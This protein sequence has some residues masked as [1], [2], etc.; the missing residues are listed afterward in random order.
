MVKTASLTENSDRSSEAKPPYEPTTH[1]HDAIRRLKD[2]AKRRPPAPRYKIQEQDGENRLEADHPD[3]DHNAILL[4]DTFATANSQL[5]QGLLD[6]LSQLTD[7]STE[8][9]AADLNFL[10]GAVRGIGPQDE[11]ET[12]LAVQMAAVHKATL[13][14]A[15]RLQNAETIALYDANS[16][17]LNK[18]ARTFT[19]Q[20]E[21]LKRYRTGGEQTIKVQHVNVH[22][23]GQAIVG[24]VRN[25]R[26]GRGDGKKRR[27]SHEPGAT[28]A[29]ACPDADG[30]ALLGHVEEDRMPLPCSSIEGQESVPVSRRTGRRT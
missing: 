2:R 3:D 17:A 26:G 13:A 15:R 30:P 16:N 11:T 24:N 8:K 22:S 29:S 9:R 10:L 7:G 20:L 4:A 27:Q 21:S 25:D 6:Q 19:T 23:G 28:T 18:L 1:E 12:L 14:A 5:C